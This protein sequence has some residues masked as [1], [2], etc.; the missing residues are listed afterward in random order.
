MSHET[1]FSSKFYCPDL[2]WSS[3]IFCPYLWWFT[4]S[5][6]EG[7]EKFSLRG[8]PPIIFQIEST[9]SAGWTK[10]ATYPTAY[11]KTESDKLWH[12]KTQAG[13]RTKQNKSKC[14]V[15]VCQLS[16]KARVDVL[17]WRAQ[18]LKQAEVLFWAWWRRLWFHQFCF[19]HSGVR[20]LASSEK[21]NPVQF[22]FTN[23]VRTVLFVRWS[24][25]FM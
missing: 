10:V 14:K 22:F 2:V 25:R 6:L 4:P 7:K 15:R 23:S 24:R 5:S 8:K 21:K 3:W 18:G 20:L 11:S 9:Q 1:C 19:Q 16:V 13:C 17:L 12:A